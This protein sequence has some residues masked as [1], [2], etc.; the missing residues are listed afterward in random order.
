MK[1][2]SGT[3]LI[4]AMR[5]AYLLPIV[6]SLAKF[7]VELCRVIRAGVFSAKAA[8]W[9]KDVSRSAEFSLNIIVFRFNGKS[10]RPIFLARNAS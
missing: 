5:D 10:C 7:W 6:G 1:T 9:S 2:V 3:S 4:V 8:D